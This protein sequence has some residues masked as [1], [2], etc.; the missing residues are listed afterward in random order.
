[1][2]AFLP[3]TA[4]SFATGQISPR[5]ICSELRKNPATPLLLL[6]ALSTALQAEKKE[7]MPLLPVAS[8]K[9]SPFQSHRRGKS[10]KAPLQPASQLQDRPRQLAPSH[11]ARQIAM[12]PQTKSRTPQT[13]PPPLAR[14]I[15]TNS[16]LA[17]RTKSSPRTA[18]P[19][20]RA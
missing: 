15:R 11:H 4:K 2:K 20:A 5:P 14:Q 16:P 8:T 18:L 19:K 9:A 10:K 17:T 1:M 12:H 7:T 13:T 3:D 6:L